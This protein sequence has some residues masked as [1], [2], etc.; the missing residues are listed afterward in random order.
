VGLVVIMGIITAVVGSVWLSGQA[1]GA[2]RQ[3]LTATFREVGGLADG[4]LVKYRGVTVG[5]VTGI[6]LSSRGDG[7]FVTLAVNPEIVLPADAGVLLSA[8]SVFGEWMAQLVSMSQYPDLQF[9]RPQRADVLPGA[10]LPDFSELTAVAAR[11]AGDIELLSDRVQLAFT[12][13]TAV[14]IRETIENVAEVSEQVGGFIDQQTRTY[15]EVSRQVL[16]SAENIR[17]ATAEAQVTMREVRTSFT[18]GDVQTILGNA[19]Q[20]SENLAAFSAQ[21]DQAAAGVPGLIGQA[22]TTLGAFGATAASLDQTLQALQPAFAE[23]APTIVEARAAMT[24]LNRVMLRMQEG[25]GTIGRLLEDPALYEETQRAV[26]TLQ[27]L[28]ADVQ[29]NPGKYIREVRVF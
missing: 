2:P 8:E 18:A 1:W 23:V 4:N 12:Q 16:Q 15:S 28:L 9:T 5:R 27:R 22:E 24:T 7:V 6:E 26:N 11:I 3:E 17:V 25:E 10:A 20:A 13:E 29:A 14:K 21:L 19:R